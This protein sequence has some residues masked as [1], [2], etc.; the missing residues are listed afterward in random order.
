M[1]LFKRIALASLLSLVLG[2]GFS[3]F[4]MARSCQYLCNTLTCECFLCCPQ[5]PYGSGY[6]CN[7]SPPPAWCVVP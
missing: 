5:S 3:S 1:R 2:A 7:P 6:V 4:L